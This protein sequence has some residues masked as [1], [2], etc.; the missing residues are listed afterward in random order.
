MFLAEGASESPSR[1]GLADRLEDRGGQRVGGGLAGPHDVLK[2]GIKALA[3]ADR[4]FDQVVELLGLE[5]FGAPQRDGVPEHWQALLAPEIEVA[6]P[7]LL[8]DQGQQ[9]VDVGM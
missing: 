2:G 3:F 6:E 7:Q 8:V 1:S 5:A 9:P 4:D